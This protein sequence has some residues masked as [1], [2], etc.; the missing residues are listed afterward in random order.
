[1]SHGC[2]LLPSAFAKKLYGVT[3]VGTPILIGA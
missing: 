3:D 2:V 1:M